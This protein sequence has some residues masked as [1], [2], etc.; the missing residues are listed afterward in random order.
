MKENRS[1]HIF[2]DKDKGEI[3]IGYSYHEVFFRMGLGPEPYIEMTP[4]DD[5]PKTT[6]TEQVVSVT[7]DSV[8]QRKAPFGRSQIRAGRADFTLSE[9]AAQR[10]K[11]GGK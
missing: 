6:D 4:P 3:R 5:L 2:V 8:T 1:L 9:D 10:A 11:S 7:K